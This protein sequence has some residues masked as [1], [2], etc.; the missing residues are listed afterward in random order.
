M[1]VTDPAPSATRP[2]MA[3]D[4]G[5]LIVGL[6][7][8]MESG[9]RPVTLGARRPA[10][11][12]GPTQIG[13]T[14]CI[15]IPNVLSAPGAVVSTST[16]PDVL[17]ATA[18][19]RKKIGTC[20]HFDLTGDTTNVDGVTPLHWSPVIGCE[21]PNRAEDIADAIAAA[22]RPYAR[23]SESAH[24]VERSKAWL[25]PCFH[26]A[27]IA[28]HTMATV[29]KWVWTHD[30]REVQA[31]LSAMGGSDIQRASLSGIIR[32]DERERSGILSTAAG[33]LSPYRNDAVLRAACTPNF[34]ADHFAAS[35]DT[36]Y[37]TAPADKQDQLAPLVVALLDQIKNAVYRR[38]LKSPD[39]AP[40]VFALDEAANI[41]PLPKLPAIASEGG[42]QGLLLLVA[43]QDLSQARA[44]WGEQ[45]DGF[46][47]LFPVKIL[48]PGV[49]DP[50]TLE[51]VSSLGGEVAVP[52][53]STNLPN[54]LAS[55]TGK[56]FAST[57]HSYT[58]RRRLPVDAVS[59]GSQGTALCHE[60]GKPLR[61]VM[62]VPWDR[63]PEWSR[64]GSTAPR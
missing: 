37:V 47:T 54:P 18:S 39:A 46:F 58:W 55:L 43:I 28:G 35:Y 32:T 48:F 16:K 61:Y 59:E 20:F 10:L 5:G 3:L 56:G 21:D 29:A 57:T 17:R 45:A 30:I 40:V 31:I 41:A 38:H 24:W 42:G 19:W 49:A 34:D 53:V 44:R 60:S 27:A 22:A 4:F 11:I 1:T 8:T 26:A 33:L 23:N 36:V 14:S 52:M 63:V 7:P 9:I 13:K 2:L 15:V 6:G 62:T 12:L 64:R 50:R 51:L 25:A